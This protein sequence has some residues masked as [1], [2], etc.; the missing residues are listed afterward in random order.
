MSIISKNKKTV[1]LVT[2]ALVSGLLGILFGDG[3][4]M[5]ALLFA[6]IVVAFTF[7][8]FDTGFKTL[9]LSGIIGMTIG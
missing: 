5:V 9:C 4:A 6:I 8:G 2:L 3:I 7:L 1:F